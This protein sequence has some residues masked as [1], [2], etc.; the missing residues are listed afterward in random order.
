MDQ[1]LQILP[2][3]WGEIFSI[4]KRIPE[5]E[6]DARKNSPESFAFKVGNTNHQVVRALVGGAD[7]GYMVSYD[8]A[9]DETGKSDGSI[10]CWMAGVIPEFR[11]KHGVLKAM[12]QNL[13]QWARTNG[14][15]SILIKTKNDRRE[16]LTYLITRGF[17]IIILDTQE[18]AAG[19]YRHVE[20]YQ[21]T[22]RKKL[23]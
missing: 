14:Y 3:R 10:Y 21:I 15:T 5:F 4:H 20:K 11:Q 17:E 23:V 8:R 1:P 12:M 19:Q 18:D 6:G 7:A 2:G 22:F 16:M 13:E 9:V